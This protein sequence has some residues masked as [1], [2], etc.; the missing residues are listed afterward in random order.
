VSLQQQAL[1]RQFLID[2]HQVCQQKVEEHNVTY[3]RGNELLLQVRLNKKQILKSLPYSGKSLPYS[4]FYHTRTRALT[5]QFFFLFVFQLQDALASEQATLEK[6]LVCKVM[7]SLKE[8]TPGIR[9]GDTGK[10]ISM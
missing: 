8:Y 10:G 7:C 4:G 1:E 2:E 3:V 9:A 6:V 5:L